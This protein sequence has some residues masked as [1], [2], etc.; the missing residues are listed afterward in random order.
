MAKSILIKHGTL[1]TMDQKGSVA[2]GN[3][4][5]YPDVYLRLDVKAV[6]AL[7]Q[8]FLDRL[9]RENPASD[10]RAPAPAPKLSLRSE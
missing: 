8:D 5:K 2:R 10:S 6:L 3:L 1:V 4:L 9:E 7:I